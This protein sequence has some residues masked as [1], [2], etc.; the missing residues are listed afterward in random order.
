MTSVNSRA[1]LCKMSQAES[2]FQRQVLMINVQ[3]KALRAQDK[4]NRYMQ[5]NDYMSGINNPTGKL[6]ADIVACLAQLYGKGK[7][8]AS[9]VDAWKR[10]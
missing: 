5:L 6:T 3:T 9:E 1:L 8:T 2:E 4:H 7:H 10:A